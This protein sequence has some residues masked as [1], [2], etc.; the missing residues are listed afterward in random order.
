[1]YICRSA[2]SVIFRYVNNEL[3]LGGRHGFV[4]NVGAS[5]IRSNVFSLQ[6]S[7]HAVRSNLFTS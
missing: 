4:F 6:A 3:H 5:L 7:K 2:Y 1:M